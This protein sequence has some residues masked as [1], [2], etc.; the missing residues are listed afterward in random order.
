MKA[1]GY[2]DD[3]V[4]IGIAYQ[5]IYFLEDEL[6]RLEIYGI[7]FVLFATFETVITR[8]PSY[9]GPWTAGDVTAPKG[10]SLISRVARFYREQ[11]GLPLFSDRSQEDAVRL[12]ADVR[13]DCARSWGPC[14]SK[15]AWDA[16]AMSVRNRY[17]TSDGRFSPH[18]A[19]EIPLWDLEPLLSSGVNRASEYEQRRVN[20]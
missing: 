6:P 10:H 1:S 8:L 12:I 7:L 17:P 15:R 18:S 16:K 5:E 4:E 9:L 11:L 20:R 13:N 14:G 19:S 3:E 2:A